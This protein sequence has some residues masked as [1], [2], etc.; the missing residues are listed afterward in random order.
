LEYDRVE[1]AIDFALKLG[2]E[3]HRYY[4]LNDVAVHFVGL[5][6]TDRAL[7]IVAKHV[8]RNWRDGSY[9]VVAAACATAESIADAEKIMAMI[10]D[11]TYR[12][13]PLG[14][15]ARLRSEIGEHA[16]ARE[17]ATQIMNVHKRD[18]LLAAIADREA[19][20]L[21][22]ETLQ[23]RFATEKEREAKI[24]LAEQMVRRFIDQKKLNLAS[25]WVDKAV[26]VVK[27]QPMDPQISKFGSFGDMSRIT[28]AKTLHLDIAAAYHSKGDIDEA[29]KHI[30]IAKRGIED[31]DDSS[32]LGKFFLQAKLTSTVESL[33]LGD[34]V[35][36]ATTP[37]EFL[38]PMATAALCAS[39]VSEGK[40]DEAMKVAEEIEPKQGT[41]V[42]IG[43][44]ITALVEKDGVDQ[45]TKLLTRLDD[46]EDIGYA[47]ES[48][49]KA[50]H[51]TNNIN[52]VEPLLPKLV[53]DAG[54]VHTC[55]GISEAIQLAK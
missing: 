32:G 19:E 4:I 40:I 55:I 37:L 54:R 35:S 8:P 20:S 33:K 31:L 49:G 30:E 9:S 17:F 11:P 10:S 42:T 21:D 43:D 2:R 15:I 28:T 1:D 26:E 14:A 38:K 39:L 24:K 16:K 13:N 53:S 50:F 45:A 23:Q 52:S 41:G 7:S 5:G 34:R 22:D 36:A 29:V 27:T 12:D 25:V 3:I 47:Y 18:E 46:S 51:T 48:F 6:E 44:L